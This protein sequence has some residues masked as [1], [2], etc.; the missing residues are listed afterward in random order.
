MGFSLITFR[1]VLFLPSFI[2]YFL[3]WCFGMN[4]DGW[5]DLNWELVALESI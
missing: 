4:R 5:L 3:Y 2:L 1:P